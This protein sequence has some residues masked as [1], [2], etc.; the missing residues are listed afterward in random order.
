MKHMRCAIHCIIPPHVL[1]EIAQRGS[2]NQR[3]WAWRTL[4][5]SEQ[6]RGQRQ[7]LSTLG[8]VGVT[9][10]G[11]KRRTIYDARQGDQLPGHLVRG[12]NDPATG[13]LAVDEAFD[14]LGATYDLYDQVFGRNSIDD[15]G[16]R[17]D[18]T[19]HYLQSYDNA[20]WN[21]QQMVFGDGDED[22]PEAERIWNRFTIAVGRYWTRIGAWGHAVR[23]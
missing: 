9:P 21:G 18:A 17:L 19:V 5:T 22:L 13:D 1:Q 12:E 6:I 15:R 7:V 8:A 16:L 3:Q 2:Q 10:A 4:A 23:S 20:F 14:G 11:Q